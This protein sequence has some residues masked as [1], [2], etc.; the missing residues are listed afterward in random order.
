VYGAQETSCSAGQEPF[1][2]QEAASTATPELHDGSRQVV[3]L[4]GY[5]QA[6]GWVPSQVPPQTDPSEAQ[7]V[8]ALRGAPATGVQ[9]P[10]LPLSA[11]ASHW[12]VHAVSQQTP[13]TQRCD[14]HWFAPAQAWPC[15]SSGMQM[16]PEHQ[17]PLEQSESALQLPVHAVGPQLKGAHVCV[18]R[19][20][21]A[22]APSHEAASVAIPPAQEGLRQEMELPG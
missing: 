18:W 7:A 10:T 12:P 14:P 3:P 13:S 11:Q 21:Q 22:P 2:S 16:P 9:V 5:A 8:R 4:P 1:P 17:V 15:A 6:A 20:G 19:A